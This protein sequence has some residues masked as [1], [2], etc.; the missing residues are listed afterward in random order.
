MR[1]RSTCVKPAAESGDSGTVLFDVWLVAKSVLALLDEVLAGSGL[2]AEEFAIYSMLAGGEGVSPTDLAR[3]MSAPG[4]TVSSQVKRMR[5]RGHVRRVAHPADRRSYLLEL[6]SEGRDAWAQA[7][8]R[9]LPVLQR[10]EEALPTP[11]EQTRATLQALRA[12]VETVRTPEPQ[13][14]PQPR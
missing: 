9:F 13:S 3:W 2:G 8:Q 10:V 6:T 11:V 12:A 7:G 5:A 4:T 14:E 1:D